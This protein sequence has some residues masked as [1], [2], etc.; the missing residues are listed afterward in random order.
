MVLID[1][2]ASTEKEL[3]FDHLPVHDLVWTPDNDLVSLIYEVDDKSVLAVYSLQDDAFYDVHKFDMAI[4]NSKWGPLETVYAFSTPIDVPIHD[5]DDKVLPKIEVPGSTA[6]TYDQGFVYHWGT[7]EDGKFE[8]VHFMKIQKDDAQPGKYVFPDEAT[9][10]MPGMDGHCPERPFGDSSGFAISPDDKYIAFGVMT[11][12][13]QPFKINPQIYLVDLSNPT[14]KTQISKGVGRYLH[15]LFEPKED[16][17]CII[18]EGTDVADDESAQTFVYRWEKGS[19]E[20]GK[21]FNPDSEYLI[22]AL[23]WKKDYPGKIY[24]QTNTKG[25][26]SVVEIDVATKKET[27]FPFYAISSCVYTKD[28]IVM[29][30]SKFHEPPQLFCVAVGDGV[31]TSTAQVYQLTQW[32][33]ERLATVYPFVPT[34]EMNYQDNPPPKDGQ[35]IHAFY[36][37]PLQA[38]LNRARKDDSTST[39]SF[40][41]P[42]TRAPLIMY[43]HGGPE[44]GW[45]DD[46]SDRWNPQTLTHM[47]YAVFA[48]NFHGSDSYGQAFTDSIKGHWGEQPFYDIMNGTQYITQQSERK[49]EIDATRIAAMGASFG[50]YTMN[51]LQVKTDVFKAIIC[52]DGLFDLNSFFSETDEV[53]FY[54]AEHYQPPWNDLDPDASPE[55]ITK[56]KGTGKIFSP[57]YHLKDAV[58][59]T[60]MLVFH[61]GVD[62]R[63]PLSQGIQ[64]FY[65]LSGK[66]VPTRFVYF[67]N[68]NH[69]VLNPYNS[70]RWH[71]EVLG[72]LKNYV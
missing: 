8:H 40:T 63:V 3:K 53:Y 65:A 37:S 29:M 39:A 32:N 54:E 41:S 36:L 35:Q 14:E 71:Q 11:G 44:A 18:Y 24:A 30:K 15:P 1:V 47:G 67:P 68:E 64:A 22:S 58:Y 72:W 51:W 23:Q 25:H 70:I 43:I 16:W 48:P 27:V 60:P 34:E 33:M 12:P 20:E 4:E 59:R 13:T 28:K 57:S 66:G 17:S 7:F 69:W 45:T 21:V 52:H 19:E 42:H 26:P 9:D 10:I 38:Y 5:I 55:D 6:Q 2:E 61:G 50:G 31:D 46:W 49:D 62:Y 56:E